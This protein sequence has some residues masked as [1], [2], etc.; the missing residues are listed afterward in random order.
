MWGSAA[1]SYDGK[2]VMFGDLNSGFNRCRGN[3]EIPSSCGITGA[4]GSINLGADRFY[5]G[6][7]VTN[8]CDIG[9]ATANPRDTYNRGAYW[10]FDVDDGSWPVSSVK[11]GRHAL[12]PAGE[13]GLHG[14]E[15]RVHPGDRDVPD[16]GRLGPRRRGRHRRGTT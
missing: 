1:F 16:H 14:P 10:L 7:S 2:Q 5:D 8:E 15:R 13:P 6:Q 12:R 11:P 3:T 4:T 9:T